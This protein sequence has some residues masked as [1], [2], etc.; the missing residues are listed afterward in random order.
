MKRTSTGWPGFKVAAAGA[1]AST[2]KTSL[3][4]LPML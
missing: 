2:M 3:L 1:S 4:R